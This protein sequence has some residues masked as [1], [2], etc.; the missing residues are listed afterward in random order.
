MK[1]WVNGREVD[2]QPKATNS[3]IIGQYVAKVAWKKG[4][5][6]ITFALATNHGKAWGVQA[7]VTRSKA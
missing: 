2:C 4:V 5:N 3:A 6:R 7:R 1:V